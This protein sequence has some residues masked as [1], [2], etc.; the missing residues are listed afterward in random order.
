MKCNFVGG[1]LLLLFDSMLDLRHQ[2]KCHPF[3]LF[4]IL[5]IKLLLNHLE[6]LLFVRL[7]HFAFHG[8]LI[9]CQRNLLFGENLDKL[10]FH[11]CQQNEDNKRNL[12]DYYRDF[13]IF[14]RLSILWTC[15]ACLHHTMIL[16]K[17]ERKEN[18]AVWFWRL[19]ISILKDM[20]FL[21]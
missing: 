2:D 7:F 13:R 10:Y 5:S 4:Y 9:V 18:F 16:R 21:K 19:V 12:Y 15:W 11:F 6:M 1:L 3:F 8:I 17:Y 14:I 20:S